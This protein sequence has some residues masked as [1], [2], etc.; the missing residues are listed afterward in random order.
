[1]RNFCHECWKISD[2][3]VF[4]C[5]IS[6]NYVL[7]K[8]YIP[9][10]KYNLFGIVYSMCMSS[11]SGTSKGSRGGMFSSGIPVGIISF[12]ISR[13][14]LRNSSTGLILIGFSNV[15]ATRQRQTKSPI[16]FM[17]M[18]VFKLYACDWCFA[19]HLSFSLPYLW[20]M[21]GKMPNQKH[22]HF[23]CMCFWWTHI[24]QMLLFEE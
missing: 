10:I 6:F 5:D 23:E 17:V 16:V 20:T 13:I 22:V 9:I 19:V 3:Q 1:M 21:L 12:R 14:C 7:S 15:V 18:R 4:Y 24:F 8:I 11:N 2:D